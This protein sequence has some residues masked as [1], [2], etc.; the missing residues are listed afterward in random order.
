MMSASAS[1]DLLADDELELRVDDSGAVVC[2]WP[3][4]VPVAAVDVL[5]DDVTVLAWF[6]RHLSAEKHRFVSMA[7]DVLA[8]TQAGRQGYLFNVIHPPSPYLTC[9]ILAH[10]STIDCSLA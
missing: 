5:V 9:H 3:S 2:V 1:Y 8:T 4:D 10:A 7:V 6:R